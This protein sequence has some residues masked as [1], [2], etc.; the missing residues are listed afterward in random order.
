MRQCSISCERSDGSLTTSRRSSKTA[1]TLLAFLALVLAPIASA[2]AVTPQELLANPPKRYFN[3]YARMVEPATTA[4]LESELAN[5]ER[6][7]ANQ[8]VVGYFPRC[9]ASLVFNNDVQ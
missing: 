5:F 4:S 9:A 2:L 7:T 3:D 6:E 8:I 1:L